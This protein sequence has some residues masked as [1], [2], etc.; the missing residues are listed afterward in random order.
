MKNSYYC[1]MNKN[2]L[3]ILRVTRKNIIELLNDCTYEEI[4]Q[5]PQGFSNSIL[6]NFAHIAI[7]QQ[8]LIYA[9]SG[10]EMLI[11]KA[12]VD[13]FRKGQTGKEILSKEEYNVLKSNFISFTD[14]LENDYADLASREYSS[15]TTSYNI[16]LNSLDEAIAF[17]NTHEAVHFGIMMAQKKLL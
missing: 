10:K 1:N 15:Y 4:C 8:L 14:S 5:I 12:T 16:T 17:N 11:D 6:W 13:L 9:L 7:V 2:D 3:H